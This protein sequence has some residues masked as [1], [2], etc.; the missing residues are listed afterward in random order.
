MIDRVK[1]A[2]VEEVACLIDFGVPHD[3][4]V[5]SFE[6]MAAL[7][8]LVADARPVDADDHSIPMTIERH[9]VTHLQC[10]PS[11][12][13]VLARDPDAPA[14]ARAPAP[15]AGRRR[16]VSAQARRVAR[17]RRSRARHQHVRPDRDDHL[18]R[19]PRRD[20]R[21]GSGAD[22][23]A[24]RQHAD[25]RARRA[26]AAGPGGRRRRALHRRRRRRARLPPAARADARALRAATPSV[27]ARR[28]PL[29]HGRPRAVRCRRHRSSSSAASIT[30]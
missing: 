16:G 3:E 26:S 12:A 9:Q 8:A 17:R 24:D 13:G 20:R 1:A 18:V 14:C 27:G 5:G 10:T 4:V 30:R 23:P 29:P 7:R 25:L 21:R 2:G 15:L 19:V 11:L 28:P 22:R 6:R